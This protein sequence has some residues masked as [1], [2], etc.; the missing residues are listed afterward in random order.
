MGGSLEQFKKKSKRD[1][2]RGF[3]RYPKEEIL[4]VLI[5][6]LVGAASFGLGRLSNQGLSKSSIRVIHPDDKN[7]SELNEA[8]QESLAS[9]SE[10]IAAPTNSGTV[11]VSKN[12][13]VYHLPWCP[14]ALKI[15]PENK[16]EFKS[17][18]EA[19]AGGFTPAANCK[20]L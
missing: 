3:I 11:V 6:I 18:A 2:N 7:I 16:I 1:K 4:I 15:K 5:I 13:K 10:T 12:G 8:S 19:E 9:V 17:A 14:G 20:G